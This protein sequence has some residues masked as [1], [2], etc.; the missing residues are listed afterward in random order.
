[1]MLFSSDMIILIIQ[2]VFYRARSIPKEESKADQTSERNVVNGIQKLPQNAFLMFARDPEADI[3]FLIDTGSCYSFL[4]YRGRT[5][6]HLITD[7]L[8]AV[9]GTEIPIY[10]SETLQ[11]SLNSGQLFTWQFKRAEVGYPIIGL[12]FLK[13]FNILID[14]C[15]NTL[16]FPHAY[17][18]QPSMVNERT[19]FEHVSTKRNNDSPQ[20]NA[21]QNETPTTFEQILKKYP[22]VFDLDMFKEA[23]KHE[24]RHYI[25]TK[26]IP[27]CGKVRRM[28]PEKLQALRQELDYLLELGVI[29][30]TP[31]SPWGRLV[32]ASLFQNISPQANPSAGGWSRIIE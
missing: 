12:D 16:T 13:R 27:F 9:N 25:R 17:F 24:A 26:G 28:S 14:P 22:D 20:R 31:Y 3:E 30:E 7:Y 4:P 32:L 23:P 15:N 18:G 1:M 8:C 21:K 10:G 6:R 2:H 29:A 19:N 11:I 5:A